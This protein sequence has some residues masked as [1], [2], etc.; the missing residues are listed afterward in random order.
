MQK[1]VAEERLQSHTSE[2]QSQRAAKEPVAC[3]PLDV[4]MQ[5][6]LRNVMLEVESP[7]GCKAAGYVA[8]AR[9]RHDRDYLIAGRVTPHHFVP[10]MYSSPRSFKALPG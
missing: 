3:N 7:P 10:A 2:V 9:V 6:Y 8:M 5:L 4:P 1:C